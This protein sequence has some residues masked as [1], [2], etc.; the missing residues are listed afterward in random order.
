MLLGVLGIWGARGVPRVPSV[1]EDMTVCCKLVVISSHARDMV[2]SFG[3]AAVTV[4]LRGENLV[5][6]LVV[7]AESRAERSSGR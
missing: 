2:S 5:L 4:A 6:G 7:L 3:I 1:P